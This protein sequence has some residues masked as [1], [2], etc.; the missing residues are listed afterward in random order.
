M[1]VCSRKGGSESVGM[2]ISLWLSVAVGLWTEISGLFFAAEQTSLQ[3]PPRIEFPHITDL[4]I[5]S[6]KPIVHFLA[7]Q[8]YGDLY[9]SSGTLTQSS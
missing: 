6:L 3:A 7:T 4:S 8:K 5:G 2:E 9:R 1:D